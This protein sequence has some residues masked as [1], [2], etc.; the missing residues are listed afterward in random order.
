MI[1]PEKDSLFGS[2]VGFFDFYRVCVVAVVIRLDS[3][4][5]LNNGES[6]ADSTEGK[7][8][9]IVFFLIVFEPL[10][11]EAIV[12]GICVIWFL[13]GGRIGGVD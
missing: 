11:E 9:S 8:L 3:E 1:K 2:V 13:F 12:F 5:V 6:A 10:V 4:F 7:V